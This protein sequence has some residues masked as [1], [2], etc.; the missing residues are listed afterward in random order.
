MAQNN[1]SLFLISGE[2]SPYSALTR[3][4]GSLSFFPFPH[5][6]VPVIKAIKVKKKSDSESFPKVHE[7][8]WLI[9]YDVRQHSVWKKHKSGLTA[10]IPAIFICHLPVKMLIFLHSMQN[11]IHIL[12]VEKVLN[13]AS[14]VRADESWIVFVNPESERHAPNELSLIILLFFHQNMCSQPCK[15]SPQADSLYPQ[16]LVCL[17]LTAQK[18]SS[19]FFLLMISWLWCPCLRI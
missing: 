13:G 10:W 4:T 5:C 15:K 16:K 1:T 9:I 6:N 2:P 3:D 7:G 12:W 11:W 14:S 17:P 8:C 19:S 18:S